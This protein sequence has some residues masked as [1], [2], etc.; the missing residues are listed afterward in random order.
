MGT[1]H[2]TDTPYTHSTK[3]AYV[4]V[5]ISHAQRR[6]VH[7]LQDIQERAKVKGARLAVTSNAQ[8]N[9]Q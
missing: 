8:L 1:V 4:L 7:I 5:C 6:I 3:F 9:I 2:V